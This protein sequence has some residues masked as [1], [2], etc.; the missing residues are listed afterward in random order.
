MHAMLSIY[1][2]SGGPAIT[3]LRNCA[4]FLTG[5]STSHSF[6]NCEIDLQVGWFEGLAEAGALTVRPVNLEQ[7]DFVL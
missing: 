3:A 4:V 1:L 2:L 6:L 7:V 5:N